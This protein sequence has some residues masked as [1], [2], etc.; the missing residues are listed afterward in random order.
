MRQ[1]GWWVVLLCGAVGAGLLFA[2]SDAVRS[3]PSPP[4]D[5][6]PVVASLDAATRPAERAV[7][8]DPPPPAPAP[9]RQA[10]PVRSA[11][12]AVRAKRFMVA[13]TDPLA[14][15]AGYDV[16]AENGTAV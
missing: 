13:A 1:T 15:W 3:N 4:A 10:A 5:T 6:A 12:P 9:A 11:Q 8:S 16:L 2:V 14:T 7:R